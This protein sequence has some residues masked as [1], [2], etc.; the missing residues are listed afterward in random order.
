[1]LA[2]ALVVP[3]TVSAVVGTVP[4][5]SPTQP[6]P[7]LLS[8]NISHNIQASPQD[9]TAGSPAGPGGSEGGQLN[10]GETP[11]SHAENGGAVAGPTTQT[12]GGTA[13]WPI[14]IIVAILFVAGGLIYWQRRSKTKPSS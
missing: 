12:A 1:L 7:E 9:S 6:S 8:P 4:P 13:R 5:P 14:I 10:N 3:A 11:D 2:A